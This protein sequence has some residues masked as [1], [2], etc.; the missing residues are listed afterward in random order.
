MSKREAKWR[1]IVRGAVQYSNAVVV[2]NR[3]LSVGSAQRAE[4][5]SQFLDQDKPVFTK[6]SKRGFTIYSGT[7]K[8]VRALLP[9]A[10]LHASCAPPPISYVSTFLALESRAQWLTQLRAGSSKHHRNRNGASQVTSRSLFTSRTHSTYL[11]NPPASHSI[12]GHCNDGLRRARNG[13]VV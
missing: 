13:G 3:I 4:K 11:L 12:A 1:T 10:N 8:G 5:L 7:R 2:N 6:T 9:T